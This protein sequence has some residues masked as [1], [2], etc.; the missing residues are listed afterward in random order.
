MEMPVDTVL[1][2]NSW[3]F[4]STIWTVAAVLIGALVL[5]RAFSLTVRA[6]RTM[7]RRSR[8]LNPLYSPDDT[9]PPLQHD[10]AILPLLEWIAS[11][12]CRAVG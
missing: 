12:G 3:P 4:E 5:L 6:P 9:K 10:S 1:L 7:A 2:A 8:P 11:I